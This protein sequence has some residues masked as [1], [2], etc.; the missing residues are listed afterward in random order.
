MTAPE[1]ILALELIKNPLL[2]ELNPPAQVPAFR[3]HAAFR[4]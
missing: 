2:P 3:N 4:G 1:A